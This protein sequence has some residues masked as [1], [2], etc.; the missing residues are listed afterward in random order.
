[1]FAERTDNTTRAPRTSLLRDLEPVDT[2]HLNVEEENGRR[3]LSERAAQ[4]GRSAGEAVRRQIMT[5]SRAP[6][7]QSFCM[8]V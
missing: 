6:Q 7:T 2:R 3:E 5:S 1:M 4:S 8:G